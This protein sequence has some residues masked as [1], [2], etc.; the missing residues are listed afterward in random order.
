MPFLSYILVDCRRF[1]SIY[2]HFFAI[3]VT[4]PTRS[5]LS[6][7]RRVLGTIKMQSSHVRSRPNSRTNRI[8]GRP[9]D[10]NLLLSVRSHLECA[11]RRVSSNRRR[12]GDVGTARHGSG[13]RQ[14]RWQRRISYV[15]R[16]FAIRWYECC[17]CCA[18]LTS[19]TG[20]VSPRLHRTA[21][22]L[23]ARAE[24]FVE[25]ADE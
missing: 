18:H 7:L 25:G 6:S 20:S 19:A 1:C 5:S 23:S 2:D 15:V 10:A 22:A 8:D 12:L 9:S 4:S 17:D 16:V 21:S 3:E 14:M 11:E 13:R 24:C